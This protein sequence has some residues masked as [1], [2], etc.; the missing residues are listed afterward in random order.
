[1]RG[2]ER[3]ALVLAVVLSAGLSCSESSDVEAP[4]NRTPQLAFD[5]DFVAVAATDTVDL[6]AQASDPDGDPVTFIWTT[7][8]GT[9]Q[10]SSLD[11]SRARWFVPDTTGTATIQV[12]A[13]D[14][15]HTVARSA[16]VPVGRWFGRDLASGETVVLDPAGSPWI[17]RPAAT[18]ANATRIV[19][20][21]GA[22]LRIQPGT[23]LR[24]DLPDLQIDV[25]GVLQAGSPGG[26]AIAIAPNRS[27]ASAG[28][29]NGIKVDGSGVA[30]LD[31]VTLEK[32]SIGLRGR[33]GSRLI[34][35]RTRIRNCADAALEFSS[36]D[37][38][39]I[40]HS[41]L[42]AS[43]LGLR[44]GSFAGPPRWA[45]ISWTRIEFN[46]G[47][48]IRVEFPTVF[49]PSRTVL[50]I[51]TCRIRYNDGYGIE[52]HKGSWVRVHY[53][54]LY[55][56]DQDSPD[57][58]YDVFVADDFDTT[59]GGPTG[60]IDA[61]WNYWGSAPADSGAVLS[62]VRD[63]LDRGSLAAQVVISGWLSVSVAEGAGP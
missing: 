48:G 35:K 27:T 6:V 11:P 19:V 14:G 51:D 18:N 13:S 44:I 36:T 58:F 57:T 21:S 10:A 25:G 54:D 26:A 49:M 46:S 1:M 43:K 24:V 53:S 50:E 38:L 33:D 39:R 8:L 17:L 60:T 2:N 62:H 32:A 22:T 40:E 31:G 47:P 56:N 61:R 4:T 7:T 63:Q 28:F 3:V 23:E 45:R 41:A 5:P 37:T 16:T 55:F 20:P 34:V 29:W 30:I 42:E 12:Q 59:G 52:L 15:Q 9:V